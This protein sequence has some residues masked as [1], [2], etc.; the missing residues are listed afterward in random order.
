MTTDLIVPAMPTTCIY[1][2]VAE[3]SAHTWDLGTRQGD[4]DQ[5]KK[6]AKENTG[7]ARLP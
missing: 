5:H 6:G 7:R 1:I 3:W 4:R 2:I